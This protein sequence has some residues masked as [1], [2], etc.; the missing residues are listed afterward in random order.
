MP[1]RKYVEKCKALKL[2]HTFGIEMVI[3]RTYS[4]ESPY[5]N[6]NKM[7]IKSG[8]YLQPKSANWALNIV[9]FFMLWC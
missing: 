6:P 7:Y 3:R 8:P 2:H 9:L 1:W 5:Y 4:L